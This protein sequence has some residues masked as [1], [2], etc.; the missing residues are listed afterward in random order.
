MDVCY[1]IFIT[2]M[3]RVFNTL[4]FNSDLLISNT[5]PLVVFSALNCH[6][7]ISINYEP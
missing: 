2:G 3:F 5:P 6:Q 4:S 7:W 1:A